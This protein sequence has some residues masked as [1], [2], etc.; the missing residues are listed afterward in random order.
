MHRIRERFHVAY[1]LID[2]ICLGLAFY[3]CYAIRYNQSIW[4]YVFLPLRWQIFYLPALTEYTSVFLLWAALTLFSLHR[5]RLF[6][7]DRSIS[8]LKESW[9]VFKA[10][11]YAAVPT[12]AAVFLLQY[13]IYSRLVFVFSWVAAY[14]LLILWRLAKRV[15]IK[16]RISKGLGLVRVLIIGGGEVAGAVL[17]ELKRHSFLGFEVVGV[18]SK[19]RLVD[20]NVFGLPVLGNYNDLEKVIQK[21]YIDE[22]F[23][24]ES[25]L[26]QT[27]EKFVLIGREQGCGV[28][29]VPEGFKHIYGEFKTYNL[30]YLHFLEYG[31]KKLHGTELFTKRLFDIII[32]GI[33]LL[34]LS[35]VFLFFALLIKLG[36]KGSVFYVSQRAGRKG[37]QFDFYKFRSMIIDADTM[38]HDLED[39]SEVTGPV[40]KIKDDPR[41][42][43]IGKLMRRYSIDELPQLWNVLKGDMSLVGPRPPIP[44]EVEG[45]DLWQLR[46]L[47]VKPG[48]TCLWQIK[49]RSDLE[50]YKW[51]TWD[52]WYIDNW[53]FW[54]DIRILFLTIPAVLK[55]AG[56]Y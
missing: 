46:R 10:L 36:D 8:F 26:P 48:I 20:E 22:V 14:L 55:G 18:L 29:I 2:F 47:E 54:L 51:V 16:Y 43:K 24:S 30:G 5:F 15:Y 33:L 27:L 7:T 4:W 49:G 39:K 42:T 19:E 50:F 53:S 13:K 40:F 31:F 3:I 11:I 28:K 21:H 34:L 23:V 9:L 37:K 25:L 44:A 17:Q 56:A 1:V 38:K 35:P 45:Y 41:I 32:S 52:L 12:A 6:A